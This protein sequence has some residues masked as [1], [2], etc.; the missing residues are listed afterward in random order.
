VVFTK[1]PIDFNK[2]NEAINKSSKS[3][4]ADKFK[5]ALDGELI[6]NV[7]YTADKK[8]NFETSVNGGNAVLINIA[9]NK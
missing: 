9:V 2:L 4:Y 8:I 1:S 6:Q 5:D 7:Q 3:T